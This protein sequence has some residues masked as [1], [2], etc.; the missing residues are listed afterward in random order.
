VKARTRFVFAS[1]AAL[2]TVACAAVLG[3][4]EPHPRPAIG[5]D[6]GSIDVVVPIDAPIPLVDG[7]TDAGVTDAYDAHVTCT[8]AGCPERIAA[9]DHPL[10]IAVDS[11]YVYWIVANSSSAFRMLH[12][13]GAVQEIKILA[14]AGVRPTDDLGAIAVQEVEK[15]VLWWSQSDGRIYYAQTDDP[16]L[17]SFLTVGQDVV[18]IVAVGDDVFW[19]TRSGSVHSQAIGT[20]LPVTHAFP[21][22]RGM[23]VESSF[24]YACT[25]PLD[26]SAPAI[27]TVSSTNLTGENPFATAAFMTASATA[28]RVANQHVFWTQGCDSARHGA[29]QHDHPPDSVQAVDLMGDPQGFAVDLQNAYVAVAASAG[30][31]TKTVDKNRIYRFPIAPGI[32]QVMAEDQANPRDVAVTD[33]TIYWVNDAL[34]STGGG[35]MKLAK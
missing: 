8:D 20:F 33:T 26:G 1:T 6:D 22:L 25:T 19:S 35:V 27:R 3:I 5:G 13:G 15:R 4:D 7:S 14:T 18:S 30:C 11:S 16:S 34:A 24:V 17:Y 29:F 9:Q 32:P 23:A 28:V 2:S 10:R 12:S 31:G 21:G